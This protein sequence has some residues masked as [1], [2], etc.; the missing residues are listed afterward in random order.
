MLTIL[1]PTATGKT[2]LAAHL[3]YRL[4]G[5]VIS[6]DSRQVYRGM[7]IGT[8]KDLNDYLVNGIRIPV[9]LTDLADAGY[10]YNLFEYQRDFLKVWADL[11]QRRKFPV[12]CGG[13]G[14]YI[15]AVLNNY[16]LVQ[17]PINEQLRSE[18]AGKT[19]EELIVILK[20]YNPK[21]HNITDIVN[22]KR[23]IR[24]IE[25]ADYCSEQN[26]ENENDLRDLRARSEG[27]EGTGN[28]LPI[29][30][31]PAIR[32]LIV[33]IQ[34]DRETRRERITQRL[35]QRLDEGMVEEVRKLLGSG[36]PPE[37]LLYYGLEYKYITLHLTG[38]MKYGEMVE[39][40]NIAI[41]Q[42]AKRQMTWF[43]KMEK[44]GTIIHWLDGGLA[45]EEKVNQIIGLLE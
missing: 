10:Q 45:L 39:K 8:G 37:D 40:L 20:S 9:H 18:L 4:D 33:G 32:P 31:H 30:D 12:L 16:R 19:L 11:Q 2:S 28:R 7:D 15:E 43:R 34:F 23:A 24:A 35:H 38:A 44:E 25:I 21:L 14:L 3:A 42:F 17:V 13:S 5:E 26:P 36:I 27:I 41:H 22:E 6:A 29:T 1:G